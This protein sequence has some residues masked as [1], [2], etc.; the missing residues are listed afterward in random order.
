[1]TNLSVTDKLIYR[2]DGIN[3]KQQERE[4][5]TKLVK[6]R[7]TQQNRRPAQRST[8]NNHHQQQQQQQHHQQKRDGANR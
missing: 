2:R 1:L 5:Q 4:R 6:D 8:D 7:V 3:R